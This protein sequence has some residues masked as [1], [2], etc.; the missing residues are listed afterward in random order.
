MIQSRQEIKATAKSAMKAQWGTSIGTLLLF[1]LISIIVV[2]LATP[3]LIAFI[4]N[5]S[6]ASMNL[7]YLIIIALAI[8]ILSPL[9]VNVN[10]IFTKIY[11]CEPTRV[12]DMVSNF[13]VNYLRKVGGMAWMALF[14]FLWTLLLFIPGIIK[15]ISY[16]MTPYILADCPNVTAKEALK[17]SMRMTDG[18]KA[19]LF[20]LGLSFIGWFLLSSFTFGILAIVFVNPYMSTSF[21]GYYVELKQNALATGYISEAE[22]A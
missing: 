22:L 4:S 21:A 18:H 19:K 3:F 14:T 1:A 16:S 8:F 2:M 12:G 11:R 6:L 9:T 15:G 10:G 5:Q 20:V 17:L 7:Y 13:P